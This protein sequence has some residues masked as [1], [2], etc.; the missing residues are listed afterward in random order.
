[1]LP[2][3]DCLPP[4]ENTSPARVGAEQQISARITPQHTVPCARRRA[5]VGRRAAQGTSTGSSTPS[6]GNGVLCYS[7]PAVAHAFDSSRQCAYASTPH[8]ARPAALASPVASPAA[9]TTAPSIATAAQEYARPALRQAPSARARRRPRPALAEGADRPAR[10]AAGH[11]AQPR[12]AGAAQHGQPVCAAVPQPQLLPTVLPDRSQVTSAAPTPPKKNH[13]PLA[14]AARYPMVSGATVLA[15]WWV[16][17]C[18]LRLS[19]RPMLRGWLMLRGGS[20]WESTF[21]P[22][23]CGGRCRFGICRRWVQGLIVFL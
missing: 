2:A 14:T 6:R 8:S 16:V 20:C 4:P 5:R 11:A 7:G 17:V 15:S 1:M 18:C 22:S 9:A 23:R 19:K 12:A 10:V 3:T 21:R 13:T